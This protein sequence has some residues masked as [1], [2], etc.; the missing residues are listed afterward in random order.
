MKYGE[1][2]ER[3]GD[4]I[5]TVKARLDAQI[6]ESAEAVRMAALNALKTAGNAKGVTIAD[7][8]SGSVML[9]GD[10]AKTMTYFSIPAPSVDSQRFRASI[11]RILAYM[12]VANDELMIQ[13]GMERLDQNKASFDARHKAQLQRID[14]QIAMMR[15][16]ESAS[17]LSKIFKWI[18]MGIAIAASTVAATVATIVS[19]G[20]ASPSYAAVS[21]LV[22]SAVTGLG[23]ASVMGLDA[24]GVLED[25][26]E[27]KTKEYMQQGMKREEAAKA[28]SKIVMGLSLGSAILN[29]IVQIAAAVVT[30]GSSAA[31]GIENVVKVAQQ[32][33]QGVIG[34]LQ[35][36]QSIGSGVA[37][38]IKGKA[39][40]NQAVASA[41]VKRAD[42]RL[43]E[44]KE[45][46]QQ[47]I[48]EIQDL[49]ERMEAHFR[50]YRGVI[51]SKASTLLHLAEN[52]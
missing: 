24:G 17:T 15:E 20:A 27:A 52:I 23:A 6:A 26:R 51:A 49:A 28:A 12:Q 34:G 37:D 32:I 13:L 45:F 40:Y 48:D 3:I 18:G 38:T 46:L 41:E 43:K 4:E 1:P 25:M 7:V 8:S 2:I 36:L 35:G 19:C 47:N 16:D 50:A 29:A 44:V 10:G 39:E 11:D 9:K 5:A 30:G 14:K 33:S 21:L 22:A 31:T 42:A